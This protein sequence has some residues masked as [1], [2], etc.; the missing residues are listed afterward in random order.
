[1]VRCV[2]RDLPPIISV[3]PWAP[4]RE[5]SRKT[6]VDL[7]GR[8]GVACQEER[9][10]RDFWGRIGIAAEQPPRTA[11]LPLDLR[12]QLGRRHGVVPRFFTQPPKGPMMIDTHTKAEKLVGP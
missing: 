10:A 11:C 3:S 12:G 2:F 1:M 8:Q 9:A 4:G 5:Q 6:A 7:L